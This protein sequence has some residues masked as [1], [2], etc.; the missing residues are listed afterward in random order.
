VFALGGA[1][2]SGEEAGYFST[3]A[4][5]ARGLAGAVELVLGKGSAKGAS[6][7]VARFLA[8][9]ATRFGAVVSEKLAAQAVMVVGALGGAAVNL[10]FVEHFQGLARGHFIIRRL[11]RGYGAEAVRA[12]YERLKSAAAG[13]R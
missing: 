11:E 2:A 5:L 4:L 6:P 12:E 9:I 13:T 1:G 7:A 3:R 10:A 8:P